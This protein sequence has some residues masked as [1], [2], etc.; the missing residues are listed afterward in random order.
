MSIDSLFQN[1][2]GGDGVVA[3]VAAEAVAADEALIPSLHSQ[4]LPSPWTSVAR[5]L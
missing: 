4:V 2:D 1:G 5:Y 3:L